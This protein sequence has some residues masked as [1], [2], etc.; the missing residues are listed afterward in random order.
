MPPFLNCLSDMT[1]ADAVATRPP[2]GPSPPP[3]TQAQGEKGQKVQGKGWGRE[4]G[5]GAVYLFLGSGPAVAWRLLRAPLPRLLPSQKGTHLPPSRC[6]RLLSSPSLSVPG[7]HLN[8]AHTQSHAHTC[9]FHPFASIQAKQRQAVPRGYRLSQQ[10]QL[11]KPA[12]LCANSPSTAGRSSPS[13]RPP[14]RPL[15]LLP[16]QPAGL[17]LFPGSSSGTHQRL[18]GARANPARCPNPSGKKKSPNGRGGA[19]GFLPPPD[20]QRVTK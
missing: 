19:R 8:T 11:C 16:L 5:R 14:L 18:E 13:G 9:A 3:L 2:P 10:G 1:R 6:P 15:G 12:S 20:L 17:A 7:S 4:R